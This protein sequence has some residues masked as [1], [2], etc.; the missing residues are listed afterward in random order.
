MASTPVG[1]GTPASEDA[2]EV[3]LRRL[4][5]ES[6]VTAGALCLLDGRVGGLRLVAE[7]GLSDDGCQ[8]LRSLGRPAGGS[9]ALPFESLCA[10]A[11]RATESSSTTVP[12]PPLL[13]P[14]GAP[15]A[16]LCLPLLAGRR[17]LGSVILIARPPLTLDVVQ[18]GLREAGL[19]RLAQAAED[20]LRRIP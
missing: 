7:V 16:V 17:A 13:D 4:V 5:A 2:L 9:W 6:G 15:F 14:P 8:L 18:D 19:A 3:E 20:L 1:R 10:R 11:P 12:V